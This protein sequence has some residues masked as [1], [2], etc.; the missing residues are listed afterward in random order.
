[1]VTELAPRMRTGEGATMEAP[2]KINVTV[3]ELTVTV[4]DASVPPP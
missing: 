2:E 1:M 4:C 3:A